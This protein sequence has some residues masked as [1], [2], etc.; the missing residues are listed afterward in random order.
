[1]RNCTLPLCLLIGLVL[2]LPDASTE[3]ERTGLAKPT[4]VVEG[5]VYYQPDAKR[6]WRYQRY[7]VRKPKTGEIAEA[8]VAVS[9]MAGKPHLA[10]QVAVMDQVNYRF[11]PETLAIRTGDSVRFKNSDDAL[12]N[13]LSHD[14]DKPFNI[15]LVKGGEHVQRFDRA[16]G[17][18]KP[19][20]L[21]CVYHGA[22]QAWVY[23]FDHSHYH[24]TGTDG[25]FRLENLPPGKLEL[26]IRHAAGRLAWKKQIIIEAGKTTRMDIRISPD[27]LIQSEEKQTNSP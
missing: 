4:G 9:G 11:V 8:V 13:V 16:G 26:A 14:G 19:L 1:M 24:V 25:K 2:A 22:M 20:R 15:N 12:H 3:P 27:D 21:G 17:L 7:Y 10:G 18:A 6:R 5:T 23:V